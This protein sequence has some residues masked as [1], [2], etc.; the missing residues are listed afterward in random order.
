[1]VLINQYL[2]NRP[3]V[4]KVLKPNNEFFTQLTSLKRDNSES[5]LPVTTAIF[6]FIYKHC[7]HWTMSVST[8]L[9]SYGL[10]HQTSTIKG[11]VRICYPQYETVNCFPNCDL[12][13]GYIYMF[14]KHCFCAITYSVFNSGNMQ[15]FTQY[16]VVRSRPSKG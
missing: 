9:M 1:M 16:R 5:P 11:V 12:N 15:K 14:R 7:I 2:L 3:E 8:I 4:Q 10:W 13:A 6:Q